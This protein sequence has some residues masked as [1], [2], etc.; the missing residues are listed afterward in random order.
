MRVDL[1]CPLGVLRHDVK[2]PGFNIPLRNL[3][4]NGRR[5]IKSECFQFTLSNFWLFILETHGIRLKTG[6][7]PPGVP[8]YACIRVIPYVH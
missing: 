2:I 1:P 4:W 7:R 5:L 6:Y 3:C 8:L